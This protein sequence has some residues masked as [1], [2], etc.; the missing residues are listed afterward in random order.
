MLT[1]KFI[2][3]SSIFL[4]GIMKLATSLPLMS[5][6]LL[7]FILILSASLSNDTVL[8]HLCDCEVFIYMSG[9]YVCIIVKYILLSGVSILHPQ[10]TV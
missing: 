6:R 3:I 5:E 10:D 1:V 2:S 7:A 8:T 9:S 4:L